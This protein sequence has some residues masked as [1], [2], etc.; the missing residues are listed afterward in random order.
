MLLWIIPRDDGAGLLPSDNRD[1]DIIQARPDSFEPSIGI[2]EKKSFLIIKLADPPNLAA[3]MDELVQSKYEPGPDG[4]NR[5]SASRKWRVDWRTKFSAAEIT[6][7][8][9]STASLADGTTQAGGTVTGGVVAGLFGTRD[10]LR[11]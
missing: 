10:M 11:K 7:I 5:V 6:T 8:L 9:D 4:Q 1:G 2:Q 3:V